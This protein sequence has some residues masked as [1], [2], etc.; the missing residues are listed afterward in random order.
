MRPPFL[1]RMQCVLSPRYTLAEVATALI[2]QWMPAHNL[3]ANGKLEY[4]KTEKEG[5]PTPDIYTNPALRD[6]LFSSPDQFGRIFLLTY[7]EQRRGDKQRNTFGHAHCIALDLTDFLD[8]QA[9]SRAQTSFAAAHSLVDFLC[10]HFDVL[11]LVMDRGRNGFAPSPPLAY[12]GDLIRIVR[13]SEVETAYEDPSVY[14]QAWSTQRDLGD[15][16]MLV[17]RAPAII[18]ELA[19]KQATY[20]AQWQ[21]ARA[22]KPKLTTYGA[23]ASGMTG[24]SVNPEEQD[25]FQQGEGIIQ[26]MHYQA[27][28]QTLDVTAWADPGVDIA[29]REAA[30]ILHWRFN[31]QLDKGEPLKEVRFVFLNREQA[32]AQKRVLLDMRCRVFHMGSSPTE[33]VEVTDSPGA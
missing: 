13:K 26:S 3:K 6:L 17:G 7:D 20:P 33:L 18:D 31:K 14:W 19:F 21:M 30:Q 1:I 25:Y 32:E 9:L 10:D 15:G 12:I 4:G 16:R 28:T 22:A 29:P 5:P 11:D 23:L 8:D 27:E 2:E 24:F